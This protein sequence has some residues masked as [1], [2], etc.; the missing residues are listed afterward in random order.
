MSKKIFWTL[1][2]GCFLLHTGYSQTYVDY[3]NESIE[4]YK[5]Q[6]YDQF[7]QSTIKADSL[8]PNHPV[9]LYNL[10]NAYVLNNDYQKA[11]ETLLYRSHF[12]ASD[13]FIQDEDL[14]KLKVLDDWNTLL[15]EV[16]SRNK[17]ICVCKT[18]SEFVKPGFHPEGVTFSKSANELY[19]SDVHTGV[20]Y[21]SD[22]GSNSLVPVVDL[23]E[24]GYWSALGIA[25]DPLN[26]KHI[27][28]TT[29]ALPN[30][31]DY[32]EG[33]KGKSAILTFNIE[34][35]TLLNTYQTEDGDHN[36]GDI[37][38]S[39]TGSVYVTDSGSNPAIFQINKS[40][41]TLEKKFTH[42]H[43]W[44]LQGLAATEDGKW[45]YVSDYITGIY[46]IDLKSQEIKPIM[47]ANEWLRG[48][49]GIYVKNNTLIVV[50]NGSKPK[51]LA[52]IHINERG[53]GELSTL[54]FLHQGDDK[55]NEPTLGTWVNN[56]FYYIANSPWGYY[57]EHHAAKL[58]EWPT[59]FVN[60]LMIN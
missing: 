28:V 23:K 16:N 39:N 57:D 53:D 49:D 9:I 47:K 60:Q 32:D 43:W 52:S 25:I 59:L 14:E 6:N 18:V 27:W 4:A 3:Y 48:G 44:N 35:G 51:R 11:L 30:F 17:Y 21:R 12:Y 7:L 33:E 22:L 31:V 42:N 37:Y 40:T 13:D 5:S 36:F 19:Y 20:I 50:Q 1:I 54:R 55:L 38:I 29:S 8:R 41:G 15:S 26:E 2:F 56:D 58:N 46:K 24:F 10:A 45:L 34:T